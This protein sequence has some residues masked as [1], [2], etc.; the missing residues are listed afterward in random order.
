AQEA[1]DAQKHSIDS[2]RINL[3][4]TAEASEQLRIGVIHYHAKNYSAAIA[5]YDKAIELDPKNPVVFALKGYSQ[6]RN[7]ENENAVETLN[8]AV[9]IDPWYIW[10]HY[11]LALANWAIGDTA[12]AIEEVKNV[13]KLDPGFVAVIRSDGQFKK[14]KASPEYRALIGE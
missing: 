12:K 5:A 7:G 6:L 4:R 11:D 13:L 3:G 1:V 10:S 9:G 2:M 14:F 8:R